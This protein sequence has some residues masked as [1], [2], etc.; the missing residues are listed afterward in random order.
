MEI[1][2]KILLGQVFV[3]RLVLEVKC[4]RE[5]VA[6]LRRRDDTRCEVYLRV[7]EFSEQLL[8]LRL[9]GNHFFDHFFHFNDHVEPHLKAEEL[10]ILMGAT[11]LFVEFHNSDFTDLAIECELTHSFNIARIEHATELTVKVRL[12]EVESISN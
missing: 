3:L 8:F 12:A 7:V 4:F 10:F 6:Q 2:R 11:Y 9:T 5:R 1:E